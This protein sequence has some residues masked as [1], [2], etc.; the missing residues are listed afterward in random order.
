ML[1]LLLSELSA[2]PPPHS[3]PLV[4]SCGAV[5]EPAETLNAH[6]ALNKAWTTGTAP[7]KAQP[8]RASHHQDNL[9]LDLPSN[10]Q[11]ALQSCPEA[12]MGSEL[13][14][15][16]HWAPAHDHEHTAACV[17]THDFP[18]LECPSLLAEDVP[19]SPASGIVPDRGIASWHRLV[20]S[21]LDC[22]T[23][24]LQT[25]KFKG[26]GTATLYMCPHRP[27]VTGS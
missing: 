20:I 4:H 16:V 23:T 6:A 21:N 24:R 26:E 12:A 22:R 5:F 27:S 14:S 17:I 3:A 15:N 2:P 8:R 10:L 19:R 13:A 7:I 1:Y 18:K 11:S 25:H 9:W